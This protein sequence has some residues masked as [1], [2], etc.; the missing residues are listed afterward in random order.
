MQDFQKA[1]QFY[2]RARDIY[3]VAIGTEHP[4]IVPALEGLVNVYR[5]LNDHINGKSVT[6]VLARITAERH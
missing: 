6:G 1:K 2:L 5:E 4:R 3:A